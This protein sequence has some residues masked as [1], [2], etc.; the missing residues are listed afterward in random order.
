MVLEVDGPE[1]AE[2][3][4]QEAVDF[5]E[6]V[7]IQVFPDEGDEFV[8]SRG[9]EVDFPEAHEGSVKLFEPGGGVFIQDAGDESV[10]GFQEVEVPG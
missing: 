10:E 5:L 9:S 1:F 3:E 8:G 6:V 2:A 7:V 4:S